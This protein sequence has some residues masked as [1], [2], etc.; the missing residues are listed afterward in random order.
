[1]GVT[2]ST[3]WSQLTDSMLAL[4]AAW[5]LLGLV[6]LAGE[7]LP[8]PVF[9]AGDIVNYKGFVQTQSNSKQ[10]YRLVL[11]NPNQVALEPT[12]RTDR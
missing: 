2:A 10:S 8:P 12:G 5:L 9:P 3:S 7:I 6:L 11:L 1:M 4:R